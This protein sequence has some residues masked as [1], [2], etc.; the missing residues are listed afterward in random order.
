MLRYCR[1]CRKER[2][3]FKAEIGVVENIALMRIPHPDMI[4]DEKCIELSG[5]RRRR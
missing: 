3:W 4:G 5:L 1:Q 2:Y